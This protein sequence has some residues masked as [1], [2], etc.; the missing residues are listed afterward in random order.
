MYYIT[1]FAKV[2]TIPIFFFKLG[3][4]RFCFTISIGFLRPILYFL[5]Q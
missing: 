1:F 2:Y 5:S 4:N 3:V